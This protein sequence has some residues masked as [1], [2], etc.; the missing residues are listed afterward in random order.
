MPPVG[1]GGARACPPQLPRCPGGGRPAA[2]AAAA[3][4]TGRAVAGAV[5]PCDVNT[6]ADPLFYS[7]P[8]LCQGRCVSPR[9][10]TSL[11]RPL[12]PL[13]PLFFYFWSFFNIY[14]YSGR[15]KKKRKGWR[16]SQ[17]IATSGIP[18]SSSALRDGRQGRRGS[19]GGV[20]WGSRP[21][22]RPPRLGGSPGAPVPA[23]GTSYAP[24]CRWP[25]SSPRPVAL[26]TAARGV[27]TVW[28]C[29]VV[30]GPLSPFKF[31]LWSQCLC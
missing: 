24:G 7:P 8:F 31:C 23:A 27:P 20:G 15:K 26:P 6:P 17:Q 19:P 29:A 30:A 3:G 28:A 2:A 12:P 4:K 1:P 25:R 5:L 11:P 21:R 10:D 9:F 13:F 14:I 18:L 22:P 16:L